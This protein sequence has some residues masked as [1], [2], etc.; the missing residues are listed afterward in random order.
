MKSHSQQGRLHDSLI[1]KLSHISITP[2]PQFFYVFFSCLSQNG[3]RMP[4]A[5]LQQLLG[6]IQ[7]F[8]H[9]LVLL[10]SYIS[11]HT[12]SKKKKRKINMSTMKTHQPQYLTS[13]QVLFSNQ[14]LR[15]DIV[16][17]RLQ[18]FNESCI[19]I[20]LIRTIFSYSQN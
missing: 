6:Y 19:N 7:R 4:S 14:N 13:N 12:E 20:K 15:N 1:A 10:Y 3:C 2:F 17:P 11:Y 16:T 9:G 5:S 18:Y 8:L